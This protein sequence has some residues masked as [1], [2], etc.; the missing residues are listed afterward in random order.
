VP[1][2]SAAGLRSVR[3]PRLPDEIT[4][5]TE[6]ALKLRDEAGR[7]EDQAIREVEEW[8]A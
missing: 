2:I 7:D 8:L 6:S 4:R 5:L 3:V 1:A